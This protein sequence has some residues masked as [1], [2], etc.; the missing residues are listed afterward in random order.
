MGRL[1]PDLLAKAPSVAA[2]G[3]GIFLVAFSFARSFPLAMALILPTAFCLM[4]QGSA[5][6]ISVQMAVDDRMRGRVMAYYTM[7]FLGMMPFGSLAAGAVAAQIGVPLTLTCGG[8]VCALGGIA[9]LWLR[10]RQPG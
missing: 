6:N 1:R 8:I 4:L 9:S 7:S 5:T 10:R 2:I 3:F